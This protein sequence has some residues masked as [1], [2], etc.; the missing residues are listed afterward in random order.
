MVVVSVTKVTYK[1][2]RSCVEHTFPPQW[3][4]LE[5]LA[6]ACFILIQKMFRFMT[7]L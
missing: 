2:D 4:E 1:N 5:N 6:I 7:A 3:Y